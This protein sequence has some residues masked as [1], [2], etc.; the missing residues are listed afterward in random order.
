MLLNN[1]L[2][3]CF[4]QCPCALCISYQKKNQLDYVA[5]NILFGSYHAYIHKTIS[6]FTPHYTVN[7]GHL[8]IISGSKLDH[9]MA[10]MPIHQTL[11]RKEVLDLGGQPNSSAGTS[12]FEACVQSN[13]LIAHLCLPEKDK[14]LFP[15]L[16]PLTINYL[17]S[18]LRKELSRKT[19][20]V[21]DHEN[22]FYTHKI[23]E[24]TII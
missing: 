4:L 17:F 15:S 9:D 13:F 10:A 22:I 23:N 3:C 18:T 11:A 24:K 20:N 2:K 21:F 7:S 12:W 5:T 16:N 1:Y 19:K 8:C 6:T 14:Q